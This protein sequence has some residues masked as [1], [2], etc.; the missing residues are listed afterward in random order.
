M[1]SLNIAKHLPNAQSYITTLGN[2]LRASTNV[3]WDIEPELSDSWSIFSNS[4]FTGVQTLEELMIVIEEL[5]WHLRLRTFFVA[6]NISVVDV[7]IWVILTDPESNVSALWQTIMN[8]NRSLAYKN[9]VRWYNFLS[10]LESFVKIKM[11]M[12]KKKEEVSGSSRSNVSGIDQAVLEELEGAV[13]GQVCTRFPP[14]PSG[15]LH[16]GHSKAALLNDHYAHKYKGKLIIRFDDTNPKKEKEEY[17]EAILKDLETLEIQFD[18]KAVSFTSNWFGVI[19]DRATDMVKAGLAFCDP[20]T[21]DEVKDCRENLLPSPYRNASVQENLTRW[22]EMQRGTEEGQ[23]YALR[24]K[25]DYASLNG[26]M[27]DP[28]IFRVIHNIAHNKT[29]DRYKVY[30]IYNF[31]CP[32]VDSEE[33]VTHALRSNEYHDSEEQYYWFLNNVPGLRNRTVRI[34]DFGRLQFTYTL[35]SKRKLSIFVE[36]G[37]VDSWSDPRFPTIQGVTRRGLRVEA[38]RRF[39]LSVGDSKKSVNMDINKL[40]SLNKQFIDPIIP[41]YTCIRKE[42][43][44][45]LILD[46]PELPE[47]V[48]VPRHK[49]NPSL[50]TKSIT[51]TKVIYLEQVDAKEI[52]DS[53][54]LTIMNWGNVII[55]EIQCDEN[56]NVLE[57]GGKLHLE[58]D[59]KKTRLKLTWLPTTDHISVELVDYGHLLTVEQ[60]PKGE[61]WTNYIN[62]NSV[63]V[64]KAVAE[65]S[66]VEGVKPGDSIQ[67]ERVGYFILDK[68]KEDGTYVFVQ[69][70]DGHSKNVFT[71]LK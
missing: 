8:S 12:E 39:I 71:P 9:L 4:K 41:R 43:M 48:I 29:G 66:L 56:G 5:N 13:V 50:G 63:T 3:V 25:I 11:M 51:R 20:S 54:E 28:V 14:E 69:I 61:E 62:H 26:T 10:G 31:A 24:A 44:V 1:S 6:Y 36:K 55:N 18:R 15:Y 16:L 59:F 17:E 27:R 22:E 7:G 23:K 35:M 68:V 70:P 46:G 58:G 2:E 45:P 53:E 67:F 32:V 34:K 38:L 52:K 21:A 65:S 19:I 60:I 47:I 30:P 64:T 40:W 49:K 33:G 37:L 42:K 57:L